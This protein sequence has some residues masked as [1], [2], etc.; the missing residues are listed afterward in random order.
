MKIKTWLIWS[1]MVWGE[2]GGNIGSKNLFI[3]DV[4]TKTSTKTMITFHFNNWKFK[5]FYTTCRCSFSLILVLTPVISVT[6]RQISIQHFTRINDKLLTFAV[7]IIKI[8]KG[9]HEE[10]MQ[11]CRYFIYTLSTS[12]TKLYGILIY[13]NSMLTFIIT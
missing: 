7:M 10:C 4:S 2:S 8:L 6:T 5:C 11:G 12:N 13:F 9:E 3:Y 1:K